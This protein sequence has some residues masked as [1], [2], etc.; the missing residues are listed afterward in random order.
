MSTKTTTT[1]CPGCG[2]V[3]PR[4]DRAYDRKY[5]ASA[6]CWA[7]FEQ[8]IAAEFENAPLFAQVHQRSIDAYALQHAGG[9]HPDKSV[10]I[11]LVGLYLVIE[12]ALA[13]MAAPPI[14]QRVAQR[15]EWPHLEPPT[16]RAVLTVADVVVGG[17]Q[18]EHAASV[19]TWSDAVWRTWA[20][21]H[22]VARDLVAPLLAD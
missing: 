12:K 22:G 17:T 9:A 5:N 7:V 15:K 14:M 4:G 20:P 11:H 2:L 16:E 6:E 19:R 18:E 21:Y 8:V 3:R 1:T 13:P 10:C